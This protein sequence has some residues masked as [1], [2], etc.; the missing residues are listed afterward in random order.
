[1]QYL[2]IIHMKIHE[3]VIKINSSYVMFNIVIS[4]ITIKIVSEH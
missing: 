4:M 1:M 2:E 3:W